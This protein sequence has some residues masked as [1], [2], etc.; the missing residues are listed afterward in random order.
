MNEEIIERDEN[1]SAKAAGVVRQV[2]ADST[3]STDSYRHPDLQ[4]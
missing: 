3:D 1:M 2:A 4:E